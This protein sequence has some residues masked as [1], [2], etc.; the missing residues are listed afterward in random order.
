MT[1]R[2]STAPVRVFLL[3][4]AGLGA[5]FGPTVA[6]PQS[7]DSAP[8]VAPDLT[9]SSVLAEV[10][11]AGESPGPR[12]WRVSRADHVLWLLGTLDPLP[13]KMVWKSREVEAVLG[14]VQ[15]VIPTNPAVSVHANP[16]TWVGLY[17]QW[18]GV[19]ALPGNTRVQELI[20]PPLYGRFSDLV[21]RYD[22][23]DHRIEHLKPV[24]A[25]LRLYRAA[26]DFAH[27]APGNQAEAAVL[28]LAH[29]HSVSIRQSKLKIDDPR[30]LVTQLGQIPES[31]QEACLEAIV[32]R[33][34][35]GMAPMKEEA[36][37]WAQ[38]DVAALRRLMVPKAIDV[39]TAA[40]SASPRTRQ[41]I[42]DSNAGWDREVDQALAND[43]SVLALRPIHDLLGAHGVLAA[44]KAK[45]YVVEGP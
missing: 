32:E 45:G 6:A 43:R 16:F 40:V 31:A 35:T 4:A 17:F 33:L 7:T 3:L 44:L 19:Q 25:A 8:A 18:R 37:A 27:L 14:E 22:A 21:S 9:P 15:A 30:D 1:F 41:L 34:E 11:V 10:E 5:S 13:R 42:D 28:K 36:L 20:P 39:C 26:L 12:L 23:G 29:R 24:F 38:G 2:Q